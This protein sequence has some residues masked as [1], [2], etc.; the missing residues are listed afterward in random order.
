ME[1]IWTTQ[2]TNGIKYA[3]VSTGPGTGNVQTIILQDGFLIL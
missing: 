1:I 2:T 3:V